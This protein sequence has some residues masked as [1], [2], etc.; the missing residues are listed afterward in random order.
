[1]LENVGITCNKNQIPFDPRPPFVTSGVR[2]GIPAVTTRG[3]KEAEML[4]IAD[5]I[6]EAVK[7]RGDEEEL[8]ILQLQVKTICERF[9]LYQ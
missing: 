5:I 1:M 2:L 8:E 4:T 9:P 7:K 3:M 6:C